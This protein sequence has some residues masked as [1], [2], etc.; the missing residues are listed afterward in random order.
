MTQKN[1]TIKLLLATSFLNFAVLGTANAQSVSEAPSTVN[2]VYVQASADRMLKP[3]E[4]IGSLFNENMKND[5]I[6][7]RLTDRTYWVQRNFYG[8]IFYVGNE[9]VLLFDPLDGA[10]PQIKAAIASVTKLPVTAIVY[11]HNHNDHIGN[12]ETFADNNPN[13]RIIASQE[14]A[15]EQSLTNSTHP[16]ATDVIAWPN[17]SFMFEGLKVEMVGFEN[18]AHAKDHSIWL[19]SG[20]KIA[21]LPDL[22]NPD[23]PP[24]WGFAGSETFLNY[25]A[26]IELLAKQDWDYLSGGHGNVGSRAD[27]DFYREFL[28]DLKKEVGKA[29]GE[30]TW[31]TGVDASKINAH[32]A[33]LPAWLGAI[34]KKATDALRP[35]Y[36]EYYG[37]E[38][39]T[40]KN[41]EMVAFAFFDY[42]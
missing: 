25:E 14:T 8:T 17:G 12:A 28:A 42:R 30:V 3:G 18:A 19:L 2:A 38:A 37:F 33:F 32:T 22:V 23:Q 20:E 11:S 31:G 27:I 24:F 34:S 35:K 26:N 39:A 7:Q 6:L 41:A 10:G 40:P 21:H 5:Y 4:K 13:L 29:M 36:G 15:A 9:G 1:R 16:K